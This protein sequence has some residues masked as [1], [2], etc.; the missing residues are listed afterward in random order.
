MKTHAAWT[1][2]RQADRESLRH[3]Q[4]STAHGLSDRAG[5]APGQ[6]GL[7]R[8]H[9]NRFV[10]RL[11]S[12]D[13]PG[14]SYASADVGEAIDR[15]RGGG[16]AL[17]ADLQKDMESVFGTDFSHVRVHTDTT[18]DTL[19]RSLNALAFTTGSDVYFRQGA[20][21]PVGT[22]GRRRLAHELTHVVQQ[23]GS[24]V[25]GKLVIGVPGDVYEQQADRVGDEV[26][27]RPGLE[28]ASAHRLDRQSVRTPEDDDEPG[29]QTAVAQIQRDFAIE[30]PNTAPVVVTLTAAQIADAVKYNTAKLGTADPGLIRTLRDVLGISPD[31]PAIDADLVNAIVRWQAANNQPQDGKLGPD[32]AAPLF[33]ELR[34]EG[35]TTE[36]RTLA[37][38]IRRGRVLTG[39]TY[40]PDAG[41]TP[42]PAGAGQR[43]VGF[44][45]T[46][47]F[48]HDPDNGVFAECGE[49]RQEISWDAAMAASFAAGGADPVPH[50]GFPA[51]HPAGTFIED[52][53]ATN[54]MRYGH[55]G[56]FG[57][58]VAGNRYVNAGGAL[59]QARGR[60]FEGHDDPH[61]LTTD[62]GQM[63]FRAHAVD[64]CNQNRRISP[65][66]TI[67]INW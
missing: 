23:A 29:R 5:P 36:S 64:V 44:A 32:T 1:S 12:E 57:G 15:T 19:S 38:L 3:R 67:T 43:H 59:N 2:G 28:G 48:A 17:Q 50:G 22:A 66:D 20:Y 25:Q 34:A 56:G 31:P 33:R 54:T 60:R 7:E 55:R 11:L 37:G 26:T 62:H 14:G 35:L 8:T 24:P 41:L 21:D 53:D 13:A 46:A 27:Q 4:P 58:G 9:G 61:M 39:P 30:P 65:F 18:A 63:Q 49:V 47:T 10:Q 6:L 42:T 51:A 16:D 40:T 52:R 45:L